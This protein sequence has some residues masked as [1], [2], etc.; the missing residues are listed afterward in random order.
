[1]YFLPGPLSTSPVLDDLFPVNMYV[2]NVVFPIHQTQMSLHEV[3]HKCFGVLSTIFPLLHFHHA[4]FSPPTTKS[5][6]PRGAL[7]RLLLLAIPVEQRIAPRPV[8]PGSVDLTA[9]RVFFDTDTL[10][11]E[12]V[13]LVQTMVPFIFATSRCGP[14]H[15]GI[16]NGFISR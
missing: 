5:I 6:N 10:Q 15:E 2:V 7:H 16:R 1:V 8:K 3:L 12:L 11:H 13:H 9:S 4:L 14:T